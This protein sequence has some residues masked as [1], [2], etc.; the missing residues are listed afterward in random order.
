MNAKVALAHAKVAQTI[1]LSKAKIAMEKATVLM[2]KAADLDYK[3][4]VA[5]AKEIS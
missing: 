3:N 1:D 2:N 4:Q 5:S